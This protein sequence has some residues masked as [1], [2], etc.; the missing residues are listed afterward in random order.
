MDNVFAAARE[1]RCSVVT[2]TAASRPLVQIC[3]R[4]GFKV[5]QNAL[6]QSAMQYGVGPPMEAAV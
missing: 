5:E 1:R 2:L 3:S 4:Y 6:A